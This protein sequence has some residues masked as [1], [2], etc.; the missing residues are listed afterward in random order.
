MVNGVTKLIMMKSDVLD[1]F[2]TIKACVAYKQHGQQ[3]DYFPYDIEQ[4]IEPVYHELPGWK[5]D[6]THLTSEDQF[7]KAFKDYIDFLEKELE[8]PIA[9][10]SIGPDRDQTIIRK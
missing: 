1:C 6:M 8:T 9:I 7:P 3:I 10:I 5:Q 4:G 2:D